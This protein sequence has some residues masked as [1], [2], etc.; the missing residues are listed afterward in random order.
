MSIDDERVR[1]YLRNRQQI[2]EWAAL[3]ASASVAVDEWLASLQHDVQALALRLG[4][5]LLVYDATAASE[6]WP[7]LRMY[8]SA[9]TISEVPIVS[10]S[11]EWSRGRTYLVGLNAPYVGVRSPR[12]NSWGTELRKNQRI[13]ATRRSRKETVSDYLVAYA[14]VLPDDELCREGEAPLQSLERYRDTLLERLQSAWL[15]YAPFVDEVV[16]V[17]PLCESV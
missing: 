14:Y 16:G 11:L 13:Q 4:P 7:A 12:T 5:D 10:V 8:R 9:W 2:E 1:F 17:V 15:S 6:S 3:R